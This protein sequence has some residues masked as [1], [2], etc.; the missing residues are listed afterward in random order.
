MNMGWMCEDCV[1]WRWT[2]SYWKKGKE[3]KKA[4]SVWDSNPFNDVYSIFIPS[5]IMILRTEWKESKW[6]GIE[7]GCDL[8]SDSISVFITENEWAMHKYDLEMGVDCG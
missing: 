8:E 2:V 1:P 5:M 7:I 3:E 4:F 6:N